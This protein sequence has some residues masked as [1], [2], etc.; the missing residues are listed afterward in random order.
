VESSEALL[1][2]KREKES[3]IVGVLES[4]EFSGLP[5]VV[6][7]RENHPERKKFGERLLS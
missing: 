4:K 1:F 2:G 5:F 7:L 3:R 6:I